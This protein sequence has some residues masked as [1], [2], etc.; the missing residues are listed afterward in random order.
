[1]EFNAAAQIIISI[2][3]IVGIIFFAALIFFALLW[4]HRETSLRIK[5]GT[6][7]PKRFNLR[8]YVLLVGLCLIG[9]G[10]ALTLLFG[11]MAKISWE[12]L[13]GLVPLFIGIALVIFYKINPDFKNDSKED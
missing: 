1:M 6:E 4:H 5:N 7:A 12:L 8:T 13:G 2:I 11:L 3:P 10:L 9:V